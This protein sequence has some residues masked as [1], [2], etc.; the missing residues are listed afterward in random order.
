MT[1]LNQAGLKFQVGRNQSLFEVQFVRHH[2]ILTI[3]KLRIN[4]FAEVFI[5]N[6]IAYEQCHYEDETY[7]SEFVF[8]SWIA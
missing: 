1:E 8:C 5:K 2:G 3:P 4:D 6:A 7:I